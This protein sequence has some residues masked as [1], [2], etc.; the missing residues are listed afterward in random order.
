V[1]ETLNTASPRLVRTLD[2]DLLDDVLPGATNVVVVRSVP[3][4]RISASPWASGRR[5]RGAHPDAHRAGI[6]TAA[7]QT[8]LA[9]RNAALLDEVERLAR[10]TRSRASPTAAC[11][12]SHCA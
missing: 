1:W 11:S 2:D 10:A 6:P 8:A 5:Q 12:T 4:A 3:T 7:T 9:L